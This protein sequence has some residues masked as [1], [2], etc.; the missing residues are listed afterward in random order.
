MSPVPVGLRR[1][2]S[3]LGEEAICTILDLMKD[4]FSIILAAL[5]GDK[6]DNFRIRLT[7]YSEVLFLFFIY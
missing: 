7:E 4:S 6:L 3:Q 5:V 1:D 2:F